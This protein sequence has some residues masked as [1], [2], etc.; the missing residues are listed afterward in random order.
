MNGKSLAVT[1]TRT[2]HRSASGPT[3]PSH[4]AKVLLLLRIAMALAAYRQQAEVAPGDFA[5]AAKLLGR[6]RDL[7]PKQ[8]DVRTLIA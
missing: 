6:S 7:E 5:V 3:Q 1:R 4:Q 2:T 8:V